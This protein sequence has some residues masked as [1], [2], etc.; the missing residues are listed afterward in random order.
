MTASCPQ[1]PEDAKAGPHQATRDIAAC[2]DAM[3]H[4]ATAYL[5]RR[6][7]GDRALAHLPVVRRQVAEA[8]VTRLALQCAIAR[9]EDEAATAP[10]A[11]LTALDAAAAVG[12]VAMRLHGGLAILADGEMR[13]LYD[14]LP[15]LAAALGPRSAWAAAHPRAS[16]R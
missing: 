6:K 11:A 2:L 14:R 5:H 8:H 10:L 9:A 1:R 13:R 7:V 12:P 3:L 15:G 4:R 16:R